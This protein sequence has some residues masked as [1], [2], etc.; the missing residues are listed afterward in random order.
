MDGTI[1]RITPSNGHVDP[2]IEV[3][4]NPKGIAVAND[5][6]WVANSD[7]GTVSEVVGS[8]AVKTIEVG[9]EPRGVAA[10]FGSIW[11]AIGVDNQVVRIDPQTGKV[12]QRIDAG[13][14]PEGITVGPKSVW[15]ATGIDNTLT[16]IDPGQ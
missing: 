16:R 5:R 8:E 3:G 12:V 4:A 13:H 6:E 1:S 7:D 11:V 15:V 2:A 9:S 10:G 14:G